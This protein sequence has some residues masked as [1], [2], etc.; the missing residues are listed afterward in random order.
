MND[1]PTDINATGTLSVLENQPV[2]TLI[3]GF[4]AT[5]ADI[6]ATHVFS[7]YDQN[8]TT[9]NNLFTMDGNG[10]LR[11]GAIL[12]YESNTT[13]PIQVR[14]T[15]DQGATFDKTFIVQVLNLN[16][17]PIIAQGD[18]PLSATLLEDGAGYSID[19]NGSDPDGDS[20]TWILSVNATNGTA[21]IS[22]NTGL[23]SYS[24]NAD[25]SGSESLTVLLSDG[26]LSDS[27]SINITIT[28]V[29]DVPTDINATGT[30]SVLENQ[31]VGTLIS[32]FTATDADI[33]ATHV[34]SLYDQ[35]GTTHNNLFTMDGNGSLRTGA[36]LDY[37]SN[38][39]HPIQVRVTDDQGATF[40]KTFIVQV[41]NLNEAPIIAQGDSPLSATLLEDGAGYSIDLNGSDPDGD[42]LTWILSVNATNGTASISGNTGILSYSP[43]AHYN[44]SE[45]LTVVLSDGNLSDSISINITITPVND[46]PTDINATGTLSVLENQP[47]GTLISGFTATDADINATHVFS[48]YDQNGT[49]NN[50]LFT[51]DGNGS[52]RTGAILDYE[53]NT[54]HPI[55]VRVTDDQG[56]TFDKT[57]IVQV[58]NLNESPIIAQGTV[59]YLPPFL[60]DGAGY[61]IDLNGSD[62]D[63]DSLTWILSVNA[64]NG[65]ASISGNTGLLSYS[66]NA[67][68]SGSESLTVVLSDGNLSDSIS[69]N[70]TITPVNDV[71]TDI[72]ATGTLSVLE[73]Q[74]VGTLISGFTATDADI[75][76]THLFTLYD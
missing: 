59:H 74:P 34:F 50:N 44:G 43:N 69:I 71:P 23:L 25:Y 52:L 45:S 55:Q 18:S 20:L 67:D 24:P 2:G 17:S 46:V 54:T 70:I 21:S 47:V 26:N 6:N 35:N 10:S 64:I 5:D 30:L 12:D 51:M 37:E 40:D 27:I 57:F 3:S 33:N 28:P 58:L 15:D 7:L 60:E 42:S 19:L 61:S 36:I 31:P 73:N 63:G 13:H 66:P 29:N 48:L 16:E 41:L 65:T 72:N 1:V 4:T 49:T 53:S 68:Y 9:H 32:G 38:T 62:P 76:A 56:A 14:V 22:G 11:T 75:N 8:G 39:T